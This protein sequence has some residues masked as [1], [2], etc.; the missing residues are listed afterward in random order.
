MEK[1]KEYVIDDCPQ[2]KEALAALAQ[3]IPCEYYLAEHNGTPWCSV[4]VTCQE[5]DLKVVEEYL[6]PYI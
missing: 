5:K 4:C 2:A 6:A 1:T 3:E